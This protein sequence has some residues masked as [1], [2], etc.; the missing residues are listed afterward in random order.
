MSTKWY[1]DHN[2]L[3]DY[4]SEKPKYINITK[5]KP[6]VWEDIKKQ[7]PHV[8]VAYFA[9]GEPL[10]MDEH[11]EC[12]QFLIDNNKTDVALAYNSNLS[13]LKHKNYDLVALWGH[14]KKID[15][16]ISLDEIENRGE[17]FRSGLNWENLNKNIETIMTSLPNVSIQINCTISM[18]NIG[19]IPQ[20]HSYLF[21]KGII[22]EFGFIFNTL[23]DPV[24]YRTQILPSNFK[25]KITKNLNL[26]LDLLKE[27]HP[28]KDWTHFESGLKNQLNFMNAEDY[29]YMMEEFKKVTLK[30]DQIRSESFTETFPE[31]SEFVN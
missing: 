29:S 6:I 3:W 12:L 26:Y 13:I 18:F 19:R 2:R 16:G 22:D 8:E 25:Q 4:K 30:L 1:E 27:K 17:Y 10:L 23:Q 28:D 14:F 20:I 9:G 31:M 24:R 21:A 7:L 11:Y 15:L 5:D